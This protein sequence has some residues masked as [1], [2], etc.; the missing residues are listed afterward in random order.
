MGT[1]CG[2]SNTNSKPRSPLISPMKLSRIPNLSKVLKKV[3]HTNEHVKNDLYDLS[4][5]SVSNCSD[6]TRISY[7]TFKFKNG[8]SY[9]G[10][11]H[12]KKPN[13]E[14]KLISPEGTSYIGQ[15]KEGVPHGLGLEIY[16]QSKGKFQGEYIDGNKNGYGKIFFE[17]GSIFEGELK[18][19]DLD[20]YGIL[21]W[22]DQKRYEGQWKNNMM[23]GKGKMIWPNGMVYEGEYSDNQKDGFGIFLWPN[24]IKIYAGFWKNGKIHGKGMI[25][26]ENKKAEH[27]I[28][29]RGNLIMSCNE[30][31]ALDY[32]S[33]CFEKKIQIFEEISKSLEILMK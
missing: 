25:L 21:I 2:Y 23:N 10:E 30:K 19:N 27:G 26:H 14:G 31:E 8:D 12:N 22:P 6:K 29:S 9:I 16:S 17:D 15:W 33:I 13:G 11:Y 20:G 24:S 1:C 28:W 4:L 5:S 7:S 18:N 32:K 3:T